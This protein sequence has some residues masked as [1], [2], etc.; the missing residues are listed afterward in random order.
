MLVE[1]T[2]HVDAV[3]LMGVWRRSPQAR[4]IAANR[5]ELQD[6]YRK[7]LAD[8]TPED[9][10]GSPYAIYDYVVDPNLGGMQGLQALR[11]VLLKQGKLL[12]LD[13]VPIMLPQITPGP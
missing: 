9:V 10:V 8:F 3:W 13:F 12:L 4:K 5:P 11:N 1:E 2:K 6:A 7:A